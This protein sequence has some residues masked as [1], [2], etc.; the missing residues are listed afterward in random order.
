MLPALGPACPGCCLPWILPAQGAA[1][2]ESCLHR[3]LP[4]QGAACPR[5]CLLMVLPAHG[6]ACS[7][8]CLL[9]VLSALDAACRG[10]CLPRV[11]P[12]HDAACPGCCLLMV[13]P[14]QGA[15]C[16]RCYL[17]WVLPAP[18]AARIGGGFV[19]PNKSGCLWRGWEGTPPSPS[20]SQLPQ[21]GA[22]QRQQPGAMPQPPHGT[23]QVLPTGPPPPRTHPAPTA[24]R[25]QPRIPPSGCSSPAA[26]TSLADY[27]LWVRQRRSHAPADFQ[28]IIISSA[29]PL[30][31]HRLFAGSLP[32]FIPLPFPPAF[33]PSLR[34]SS[35]SGM[36]P[37]GERGWRITASIRSQFTHP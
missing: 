19:H 21:R 20:S 24:A 2:S 27:R 5:Y 17:L 34:F 1:C 36:L 4:A 28:T 31:C 11:L 13:L 18:A 25:P 14:A 37:R 16:T 23:V 10:C 12:A 8:C 32:F 33:S 35:R 9:R 3:V 22:R 30:N 6:A 26:V 29:A 7:G 15:A